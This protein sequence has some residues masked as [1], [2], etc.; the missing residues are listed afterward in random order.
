MSLTNFAYSILHAYS[1]LWMRSRAE[2][3]IEGTENIPPDRIGQKRVYLIL[4]H[5]T[6]YDLVALMH[7][8]AKPFV[9]MV[10]RGAFTFPV[11]RHVLSAAGFIPLDKESS[12][13]AVDRSVAE[14]EAGKPLVISLHDGDSTIGDW[15][16][17]RTGGIR[18]A[19]KA[20]ATIMPV[21]LYVEPDRIRNLR[22]KGVN[23]TEYPYTTFRNTRYW[24]RF[25]PPESTE[26]LSAE[27]AYEDYRSMAN[28][29]DACAKELKSEF[30]ARLVK[31]AEE[32]GDAPRPK[33][34]GG[35][36]IRIAF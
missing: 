3:I 31:E 27:A 30:D 6:T 34:R 10:D 7:L 29:F 15:G 28:R 26:G 35:S 12:H 17:P 32:R 4:N 24:I 19:H 25:L 16:R 36:P 22:F 18:I 13:D 14:A 11:I 1:T 2:V 21:F 23:G 5:S 33:R 9:V 8:S 20:G